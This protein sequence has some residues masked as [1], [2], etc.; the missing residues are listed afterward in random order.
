M[1]N[2]SQPKSSAL[3]VEG[4]AMRGIFAAGVLDAF[5]EQ[6]HQPFQFAIGVS[7]G[8][9]NLIGY[10]AGDHG[11]SRQI[12]LDHARRADFLNWRRYLKG[13]HFCDVSWLWH[14][15]FDDVP[16]NVEHY[17]C[18]QVP[19]YAVTTSVS[20]GLAHYFEV[21]G[22]NMHQLFP[23]SCAIPLMYR[24]FPQINGEQMTDGGLADAIPVLKAYAMGAR[25]ITVILSQPLGYRKRTSRLPVLM[26]PFFKQ[27]PQMFSAVLSRTERYNQAL[28]FIARPPADCRVRVVAPPADFAVGR[29]CQHPQQLEAGYQAGRISGL[30]QVKASRESLQLCQAATA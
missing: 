28:D 8:S 14:A 24:D 1:S 25:D 3:V 17:L 27:Y 5:I 19:L 2:C 15:S 12:L 4:G 6:Q 16:L 29:F 9:T 20:T 30:Q 21:T 23:A 7:A 13:G 10:L 26:K 18:R 11:R 22:D